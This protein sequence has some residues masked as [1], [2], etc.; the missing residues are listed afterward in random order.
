MGTSVVGAAIARA[1][2]RLVRRL[3]EA[4]ALSAGS[5]VPLGYLRPLE[6]RRLRR[7]LASGA[8]QQAG[9]AYWLDET[10]YAARRGSRLPR[11]VT[12]LLVVAVVAALA[13]LT[14]RG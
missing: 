8:V 10:R 1:E 14:T 11:L 13:L 4:G 9:D 7:L 5:A 12:A 6:R 2:R 3:R